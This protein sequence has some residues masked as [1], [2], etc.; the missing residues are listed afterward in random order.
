LTHRKGELTAGRI[1]REWPHQ[2]AVP[3]EQLLGKN[4]AIVEEFCRTLSLCPRGHSV[5]RD[6]VSYRV[7][8]FADAAHATLFRER[9]GGEPFD[10]RKRGRGSN[11][12]LWRKRRMDF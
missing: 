10:P 2:I 12:Y 7:F 1:D 3:A 9:F 6:D 11:W 5:I 4:Y 8:C